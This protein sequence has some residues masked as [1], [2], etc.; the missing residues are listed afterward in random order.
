M[1]TGDAES[2][3][4]MYLFIIILGELA[5]KE[6]GGGRGLIELYCVLVSGFRIVDV[7]V[8][9]GNQVEERNPAQNEEGI[10]EHGV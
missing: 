8:G 10:Y 1:S 9:S 5:G 3:L 6:K 2:L 7:S 4:C